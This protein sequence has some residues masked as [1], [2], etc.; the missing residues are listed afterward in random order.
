MSNIIW[1]SYGLSKS[2]T[3][4]YLLLKW[5]VSTEGLNIS[6][7]GRKLRPSKMPDGGN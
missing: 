6:R 2:F 5:L 1:F 3:K 7:A 4:I